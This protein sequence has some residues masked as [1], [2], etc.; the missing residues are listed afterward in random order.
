MKRTKTI[1]K[2]IL[3][4]TLCIAVLSGV[5]YWV[6]RDDWNL[7]FVSTEPLTASGLIPPGAEG[8]N[9][10]EQ[11]FEMEAD[12]LET[13]SLLPGRL[14]RDISG[15][16]LLTLEDASG[17]A[18]RSLSLEA[19]EL[20]FDEMNDIAFSPAVECRRGETFL[21]R[22][23][24]GDTGVS[25][26]YGKTA[27]AGKFEVQAADT[28]RLTVGGTPFEGRLVMAMRGWNVLGLSWL[29]WALWGLVYAAGLVWMLQTEK[30]RKTGENN[31][32][33]RVSDTWSRYS[34][35]LKLLVSRDFRIK[36][37]AS[38][39][40]VLWSFLNPLLT[41][42]VY[43]FVFSTIFRSN[44]EQFPVYLITGIILFN[45]FSESTSLSLISVVANRALI[46]KVYMPKMLYPLAKVLSSAINLLISFIP[47]FIVM[48]VM[49]VP[50]HK[51]LLLLPLVVFF[52]VAFCLG[53]SLILSTMNVFFRDTQ[54]LW[55]ILITIWNF[56]TPIFYPET[57]IPAAFR[58]IY[59][60]N[61]LYQIVYFTRSIT[62]GGVSPTPVSYLY[63]FLISFVPLL[64]GLWIFRRNQD[65]FVL[66]L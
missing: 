49:G 1:S 11:R 56:L 10:I 2:R 52:L 4:W 8:N 13:L 12:R 30:A 14:R 17:K 47:M 24:P 22:L 66:Y 54:F 3:I 35:L 65:R 15:T 45:Y 44:I 43:M 50:F 31:L 23:E 9:S 36:Y 28:G 6:V 40:G 37:Q 19:A 55:S 42:F 39:F 5:F 20:A 57:I 18:L 25:F 34:Y 29:S 41:M 46:T 33:F 59:H 61:P 32:F 63:C 64:L 27:S 16:V 26:Q 7:S 21:L 51:S 62:L 58:T 53:M 38:V 48:L 60:L